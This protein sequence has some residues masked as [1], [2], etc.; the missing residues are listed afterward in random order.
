MLSHKIYDTLET[1][2]IFNFDKVQSTQ[3]LRWLLHKPNARM[4][5]HLQRDLMR[6]YVDLIAKYQ[7]GKNRVLEAKKV[8]ISLL[9]ELVLDVARNSKDVDKLK[10]A[11]IILRALMID[12]TH[13]EFLWNVDF[14]ETPEQRGLLT[15]LSIA[16]KKYNDQVRKAKDITKQTIY[17]QLSNI[18]SVLGIKIDIYTCPVVQWQSYVKTVNTKVNAQTKHVN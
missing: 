1:L 14:T 3:D 13:E 12:S 16:I 6:I 15:E 7:T 5:K 17:D 10:K 18:E 8:V 9:V 2:P 4:N 11:S